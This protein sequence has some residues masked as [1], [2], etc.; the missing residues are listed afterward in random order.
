MT[1]HAEVSARRAMIVAQFPEGTRLYEVADATGL[2][3]AV[4]ANDFKALGRKTGQIGPRPEKK[5]EKRQFYSAILRAVQADPHRTLESFS[6]Q[7]GV[8]RERIRQVVKMTTGSPKPGARQFT[9]AAREAEIAATRARNRADRE[10]RRRRD[11]ELVVTMQKLGMTWC[12][13]AGQLGI[14]L[15]TVARRFRY[16]RKIDL[17]GCPPADPRL[18]GRPPISRMAA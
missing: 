3:Y 4:V 15:I 13:I 9:K 17:P 11:A 10:R 14:H 6:Q 1:T 5:A 12:E 7:F 2:S 8:T 16:A 18:M